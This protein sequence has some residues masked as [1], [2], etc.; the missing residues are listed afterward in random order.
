[1]RPLRLAANTPRSFYRGTG[2]IHR[3]RG[4][5]V[6]D[7]AFHP[8][9]WVASTTARYRSAPA[10]LTVLDEG[11]TLAEEMAA[12]PERWLG[13]EHVARY[14]P[15]PGILVK[16]LDAGERLPLHVHPDRRFARRHLASPYGKTEAWVIVD[17]VPDAVVHLGFARD[18]EPDE[19]TGWVRTEQVAPML[20]ATNRVRVRRGDAVLVPAGLP[21]AIGPG[22]FLVEVQ[23]PTDFSVLLERQ[24]F[25]VSESSA[26]LGLGRDAALACVDR[27]AW[28]DGRLADLSR[29]RRAARQVR[30]GVERL[31]PE[32]AD[33]FFAAERLRP[34][35]VSDLDQGFSVV[36]MVSGHG[37][38]RYAEGTLPVTAG[39][40]IVVPFGAGRGELRG[41]LEAIRCRPAP[42]A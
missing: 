23:E 15:D 22:I 9:D 3:F 29:A 25:A 36:V 16:L 19:L 34:A 2:R 4:L 13:R 8:E 42:A 21:H 12:E 38:L 20:A 28:T 5:P 1:M 37:S 35:P 32:Q 18:V 33:E 7:D 10:G 30:Q 41:D 31:F 27:G 6:P 24:G 39:D 14:G 11:R 40:T 17:A 26:Y